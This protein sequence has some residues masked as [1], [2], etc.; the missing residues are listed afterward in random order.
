[1]S[2]LRDALRMQPEQFR[3]KLEKFLAENGFTL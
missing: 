3:A 1:L 2:I